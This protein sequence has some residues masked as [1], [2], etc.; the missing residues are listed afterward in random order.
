MKNGM[1][2]KQSLMDCHVTLDNLLGQLRL[3]GAHS[4]SEIDYIVLE[5]YGKISVIKKPEAMPLTRK[6]MNLPPKPAALPI[7][8][9]YDGDID[10]R[11]LRQMGL[12]HQWLRNKLGEKGINNPNDVFLAMLESD[13][14]F[15][16]SI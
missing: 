10:E 11:N 6:Q 9:I 8:L 14:T 2:L 4:L 12:D 16:L 15:Y 3:K 5:P 7:I 13:G 1:L